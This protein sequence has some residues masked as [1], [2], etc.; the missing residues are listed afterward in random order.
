MNK[1]DD[2]NLTASRK[3]SSN[4]TELNT[5]LNEEKLKPVHI[6]P[7]LLAPEILNSVLEEYIHREGTNYGEVEYSLEAKVKQLHS[8][9]VKGDVLIV[10][11]P[12]SESVTLMTRNEF[13]KLT[14]I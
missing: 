13:Q 5:D 11:D 2:L 7:E 12:E 9:I 8:Q 14:V 3:V 4:D 1:I 6:Q 10:F